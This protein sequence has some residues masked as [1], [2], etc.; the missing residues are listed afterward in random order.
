MKT[1]PRFSMVPAAS[2]SPDAEL[3]EAL[4]RYLADLEAGKAPDIEEYL[5][6]HPRV[7]DRLR[8]CLQ[9]LRCVEQAG[10]RLE[11]TDLS[12][13][14]PRTLGDYRLIREIGR[15]GMGIVYEAE[16]LSLQRHVALKV[17][18]FA[19]VLDANTLKRFASEAHA[20]AALQHPNIVSVYAAGQQ[21]GVHYYTMELVE[22]QSL[23]QVLALVRDPIHDTTPDTGP[24]AI[25]TSQRRSQPDKFYRSVAHLGVQ[26]SQALDYAHR[27]GVVHRD[28]KPSNLLLDHQ[29][30]PWITDFGLAV[31]N[32]E[33][34]LTLTGDL[35]GTLRYMSPEQAS[36]SRTVLDHRTDI[37]S[38]GATLYELLTL[39]PAFMQADRQELLQRICQQDP[40]APRS[41]QGDIPKD[42]E[43]I[44]LKAMAKDADR[45]YATCQELADDLQRFLDD[46]PI[47]ARRSS[48]VATLKRLARRNPLS[49]CLTALSLILLLTLAIAGPLIAL[50]EAH[51]SRTI[52]TELYVSDMGRAWQA[53]N[54][55]NLAEVRHLLARWNDADDLCGF[56]YR[57]LSTQ[58]AA[59]D[60]TPIA[61]HAS[62][63]RA[64]AI[65]PTSRVIASGCEDGSVRLWMPQPDGPQLIRTLQ[66]HALVTSLAFSPQNDWLAIGTQ[67]R[68]VSLRQHADGSEVRRL[69]LADVNTRC[70]AFS[71]DGRY[72][73]IGGCRETKKNALALVTIWDC[74]S[75]QFVADLEGHIGTVFSI[76]FSRDG[77][78]LATGGSDHTVRLWDVESWQL[79]RTLP[80]DYEIFA[81]AFSPDG[82]TFAAGGYNYQIRLWN[83]STWADPLILR[84]HGHS[85]RALAFSRDSRTL[86]S[87]GL[88]NLVK[89]WDVASGTFL[90][91]IRGHAAEVNAVAF[92]DDGE[93]LASG[94]NDETM[95]IQTAATSVR[96]RRRP[97]GGFRRR[98]LRLAQ[99]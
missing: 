75:S 42:L 51:L 97:N 33:G 49:A 69:T 58:L 62:R 7:A 28:I 18:P 40:P 85:V 24:A 72:L 37:Y 53:W 80:N 2:S 81:V 94:S 88:D 25:L 98:A 3:A 87:G 36:G 21:H 34:T 46:R 32:A 44:V 67:D 71:P 56:E 20:A 66:E 57:L 55:A 77:K 39:Q 70:V 6:R 86:A 93:T 27:M 78:L 19:A 82:N 54:D 38:L 63:V 50:H 45:R 16:Q 41:I 30:K 79:Q 68:G 12:D 47:L 22:G 29:G 9:S 31:T 43:T 14:G 13:P 73:A 15:G 10:G 4:E 92:F 59:L 95:R 1:N 84:A 96:T 61:R 11:P 26:V 8:K 5:K 91:D 65:S 17:L 89:L 23:S 60:A 52:R 48:R 64:V 74:V 90:A 76:A 99:R 83:T 35:V